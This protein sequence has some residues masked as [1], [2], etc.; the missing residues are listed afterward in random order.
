MLI[1]SWDR[2][3]REAFAITRDLAGSGDP[4]LIATMHDVADGVAEGAQ[5]KRLAD[6][7]GVDGHRKDQRVFARL[8]QHLVELVDD[9][10]SKLP[11]GVAAEDEGRR[12][13]DL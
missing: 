8:L 13:V 11:A 12:V 3:F 4:Q 9:H 1:R 2:A 10:F 7:E 5:A 6:D